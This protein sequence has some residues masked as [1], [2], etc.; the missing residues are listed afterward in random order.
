MALGDQGEKRQRNQTQLSQ[1][2]RHGKEPSL[3]KPLQNSVL[4]GESDVPILGEPDLVSRI[5]KIC[6]KM[7]ARYQENKSLQLL[8]I[9]ESEIGKAISTPSL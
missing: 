2:F 5:L 1:A 4:N 9:F 8:E 7:F 3:P 6:S